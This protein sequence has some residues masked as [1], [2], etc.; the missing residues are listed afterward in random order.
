MECYLVREAY[1]QRQKINFHAFIIYEE[2]DSLV[3]QRRDDTTK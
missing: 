3:D 2:A 1:F